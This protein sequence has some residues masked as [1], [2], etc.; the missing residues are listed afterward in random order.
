LLAEHSSAA[1]PSAED[2]I[3]LEVADLSKHF[4]KKGRLFGA[5]GRSVRAVDGVSFS[6]RRGQ[7]LGIVGE[8][9]CGKSTTGR[10]LVHLE[11]PT[12]GQIRLDGA[13]VTHLG[14]RDLE[15]YR[16]RVQMVFQD[17]T[18]SLDPKMSIGDCIAEP[19][20]TRRAGTRQQRTERVHELMR[21]VGLPAEMAQ[22]Y[23]HQLSGGQRQRVGIARALAMSP[24]VIVAD[25]PTSALDVSVRAQVVNLMRDLQAELNL[26]FIF[27]SHDLSTVRYISHEVAVMY[28]GRIVEVGPS[29]AIFAT[30]LH[31]Y[32]RALLA[33]VP[34]PD[35]RLEAER[36]VIVLE[37]E[38]PSPANPPS[39]CRFNTRCPIAVDR[40]RE[41]EPQLRLLGTNHQVACHFAG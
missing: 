32:T 18:S 10:M 11:E 14:K 26:S 36:E 21:L 37:G 27:I 6:V 29:E 31:P 23:P 20:A 41:E 16:R 28:L 9:G 15:S 24:E 25:E 30:P 5:P 2:D 8:S 34:V 19:L 40:C 39:G 7:T 35:P 33:A 4:Q 13:D 38:L 17:A 3:V 12:G 22:R 1:T